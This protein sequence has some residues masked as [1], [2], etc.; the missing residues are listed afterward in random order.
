MSQFLNVTVLACLEN[1]PTHRQLQIIHYNQGNSHFPLEFQ[2]LRTAGVMV[3][4]SGGTLW[5]RQDEDTRVPQNGLTKETARKQQSLDSLEVQ[6]S[7]WTCLTFT[8]RP[9]LSE[10]CPAKAGLEQEG[11]APWGAPLHTCLPTPQ[12]PSPSHSSFCRGWHLGSGAKNSLEAP[13]WPFLLGLYCGLCQQTEK[14]FTDVQL[15]IFPEINCILYFSI[16]WSVI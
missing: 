1:Q 11:V 7:P 16:Y 4:S 9:L 14:A 8:A 15:P 12:P 2:M 5:H 10:L 3:R 6:A 13:K